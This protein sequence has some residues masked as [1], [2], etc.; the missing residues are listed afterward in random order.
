M[1][2]VGLT[3]GI[4]SGKSTVARR[5][6]EHGA[7]VI[8]A[9]ELAREVV[10]PG[11]DGLEAVIEEFGSGVITDGGTLDRAALGQL[12]FGNDE[13]R[14]ALNAII[15]PRVHERRRE[16]VAGAPA[17]AIVVEDIP[18]LVENGLAPAYPLVIVV[19]ATEEQR[20]RRL[21]GDRGMDERDAWSR[22][23][24]Q[25]DDDERRQV[26]D[27]WLDNSGAVEQTLADVDD[28]W[29]TRLV[30]FEENCR[31]RRP[32]ARPSQPVIVDAD[33]RWPE[34]AARLTARIQHVA[35]GRAHRV[36]HVGSTAVPGLPAKDVIDLQVVVDDVD[37]AEAMAAELLDAGLVPVARDMP[38]GMP[39]GSVDTG[40]D[41]STLA[42]ALA[43]N[44]DPA[45]AVNVHIRPKESPAWRD[46]L[47]LR[48]WLRA[49]P[50]AVAEYA[51]LKRDLAAST[52]TTIDDYA[53]DKT[54]WITGA[55]QRADRWAAE[56]GWTAA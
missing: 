17:D 52:Y 48:D 53:A 19:G 15:H 3:G 24:A 7:L 35:G 18:L 25:S 37:A 47:L 28:L 32:A 9:D 12:V 34:E 46:V 29:R 40:R 16:I 38:A 45:R 36:D 27:V 21:A 23:R 43:V 41:G 14:A 2:R 42:K 31:R 6:G 10:A 30:P 33:P 1:L 39:G 26:A 20:L 55:L 13:R 44:A 5:L 22:I 54:P 4:G 49:T 51:A 11:T 50:A 8:D 56:T